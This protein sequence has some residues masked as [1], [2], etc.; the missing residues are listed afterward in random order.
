MSTGYKLAR[1]RVGSAVPEFSVFEGL[2]PDLLRLARTLLIA[3][4]V[5]TSAEDLV[6]TA[7]LRIYATQVAGKLDL[8]TVE[9]P[10]HFAYAVLRNL[11]RD[12]LRAPR[13]RLEH[14]LDEAEPDRG[15]GGSGVDSLEIRELLSRLEPGERCFLSRLY[16]EERSVFEAQKLC[17]WPEASP[18]YH[19]RQL[20]V[21]V[22]E[23]I[24]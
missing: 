7:L 19:L 11:F 14:H 6:Q 1:V 22:R 17:G 21:R 5:R 16:I 23:M 12:E 3:S 18:Y 20:L 13:T 10:R 4:R 15:D 24:E 9:S 8:S 2:R